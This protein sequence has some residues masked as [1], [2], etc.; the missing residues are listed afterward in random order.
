MGAARQHAAE[1]ANITPEQ[2]NTAVNAARDAFRQTF[3]QEAATQAQTP[4][5][6]PEPDKPKKEKP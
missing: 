3:G 6:P 4:P 2:M 1:E 5:P